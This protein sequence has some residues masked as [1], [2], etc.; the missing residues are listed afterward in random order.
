M[1]MPFLLVFMFLGSL[2]QAVLFVGKPFHLKKMGLALLVC[3]IGFIPWPFESSY[4]PLAHALVAVALFDLC[5]ALWHKQ[6]VL[7][8][9]NEQSLWV[10]TVLYWFFVMK[11]SLIQVGSLVGQLVIVGSCGISL[12]VMVAAFTRIK[13][14]RRVSVAFY[15]WYL[16]LDTYISL[17]FLIKSPSN[18]FAHLSTAIVLDYFYFGLVALHL[19]CI[20]HYMIASLPWPRR[21]LPYRTVLH[22]WHRTISKL[23]SRYLDRQ[24]SPWYPTVA[25]VLTIVCLLVTPYIPLMNDFAMV[26]TILTIGV[27]ITG[28]RL[29]A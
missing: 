1:H 20:V 23:G 18:I 16:F 29:G 14:P 11:Y 22:D 19:V 8:H 27:W 24:V 2:A 17:V 15:V 21:S 5:F 9:I 13:L 25:L 4:Y 3:L 10:M 28:H 6:V 7:T 26:G 12:L